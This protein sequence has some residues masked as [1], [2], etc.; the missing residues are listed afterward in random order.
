MSLVKSYMN[1]WTDVCMKVNGHVDDDEED[2]DAAMLKVNLF[3][4]ICISTLI[5]WKGSLYIVTHNNYNYMY[6]SVALN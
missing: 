1:T 5:L 6:G 3:S 2:E 4:M